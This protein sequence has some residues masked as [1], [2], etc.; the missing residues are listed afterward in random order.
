MPRIIKIAVDVDVDVDVDL[1]LD[2]DLDLAAMAMAAMAAMAAVAVWAFCE[3]RSGV[4]GGVL[5]MWLLC[6]AC[7]PGFPKGFR[8]VGWV[9]R[10]DVSD[11]SWRLAWA[12]SR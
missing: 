5:R 4:W 2:L 1:D 9:H 3:D 12:S 10:Q 8:R 11:W 6:S 7:G